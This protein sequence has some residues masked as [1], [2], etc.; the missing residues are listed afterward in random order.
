MA[1]PV[2]QEIY[3]CEQYGGWGSLGWTVLDPEEGAVRLWGFTSLKMGMMLKFWANLEEW[4]VLHVE[5]H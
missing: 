1:I 2:S 4:V 5:L 3:G